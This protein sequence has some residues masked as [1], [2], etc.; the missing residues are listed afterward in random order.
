MLEW[1]GQVVKGAVDRA[2]IFNECFAMKFS[3]PFIDALPEAPALNAPGLSCVYVSPG[4]VAQLPRELSPHKACGPDDLSA[5][6]VHEC[7]EEFA[8]PLD[9]I[10]RLSV[11]SGVFPSTWKR[12]NVIP[13]F[14]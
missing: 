14:F 4:R 1:Q 12:A 7:V 10:C 6:I 11:R 3:S 9:I 8:I 5:R 2:N 13:A